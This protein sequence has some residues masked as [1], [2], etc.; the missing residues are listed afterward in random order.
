M[1]YVYIYVYM[2]FSYLFFTYLLCLSGFWQL[3]LSVGF[4]SFWELIC[5]LLF[6]AE[7]SCKAGAVEILCR[8]PSFG[9]LQALLQAVQYKQ[10]VTTMLQCYNAF[11]THAQ[12]IHGRLTAFTLRQSRWRKRRRYRTRGETE[13][14]LPQSIRNILLKASLICLSSPCACASSQQCLWEFSRMPRLPPKFTS[15]LVEMATCATALPSFDRPG[16]VVGARHFEVLV[17]KFSYQSKKNLTLSNACADSSWAGSY[18][19][20]Y[21]AACYHRTRPREVPQQ[22]N[23]SLCWNWWCLDRVWCSRLHLH[24]FPCVLPAGSAEACI[25]VLENSV[26]IL[27][28]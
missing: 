12:L 16:L 20:R 8:E 17:L 14:N 22:S 4:R 13:S 7:S 25:K 2:I 10:V 27:E 18:G 11:T 28:K 19:A 9:E 23:A 21:D 1:R 3:Q 24:A 15:W 26:R 5:N 6:W